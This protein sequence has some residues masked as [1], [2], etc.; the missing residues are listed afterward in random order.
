MTTVLRFI[1]TITVI[2]LLVRLLLS[3]VGFPL[4]RP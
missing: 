2:A 1:L 4:L 3:L